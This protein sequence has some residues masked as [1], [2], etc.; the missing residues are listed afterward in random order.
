MKQ[1]TCVLLPSFLFLKLNSNQGLRELLHRV[2]STSLLGGA[3]SH[4]CSDRT[5][6]S[7][8]DCLEDNHGLLT[9]KQQLHQHVRLFPFLTE[10]PQPM[11]VR[12]S[13]LC[14]PTRC[15]CDV[16]SRARAETL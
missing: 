9:F 16:G 6:A 5:F 12:T 10:R 1:L 8:A 7:D 14:A 3:A 13:L 11:Q 4:G 15:S 2:P